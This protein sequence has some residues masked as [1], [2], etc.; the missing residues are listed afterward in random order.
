MAFLARKY[1]RNSLRNPSGAID[2]STVLRLVDE[3]T[4]PEVFAFNPPEQ[5]AGVFYRLCANGKGARLA[6]RRC[7]RIN[8]SVCTLASL[9][10]AFL[11]PNT[12]TKVVRA[13]VRTL[14]RGN[15]W[16]H[17]IECADHCLSPHNIELFLVEKLAVVFDECRNDY[18]GGHYQSNSRVLEAWAMS[19][20]LDE[21]LEL[22]SY[23]HLVSATIQN[24][25]ER[26]KFDSSHDYSSSLNS[27]MIRGATGLCQADK[28]GDTILHVA[29]RSPDLFLHN[30]PIILERYP[31]AAG[32]Q[33][34]AGQLPVHILLNKELPINRIAYREKSGVLLEYRNLVLALMQS[35]RPSLEYRDP[36]TKLYLFQLSALTCYHQYGLRLSD[37]WETTTVDLT[38]NLLRENPSVLQGFRGTRS[39]YFD[40]PKY[41]KLIKK[42]ATIDREL[43]LRQ[44]QVSRL[45]AEKKYI[46]HELRLLSKN[47]PKDV[48]K[49]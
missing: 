30:L 12:S 27:L 15:Q 24:A 3:E 14:M 17:I 33:N 32:I 9:S 23:F 40:N 16:L 29:S 43:V 35:F 11:E 26:G 28:R 20:N 46:T 10:V 18:F 4:L 42:Q 8:G 6:T 5:V 34:K 31:A 25:R 44:R 45:Q 47:N 7:I 48:F 36:T 39:Y 41:I 22:H 49:M 37:P 21:S 13:I 38:Y 19:R 2:W 1:V